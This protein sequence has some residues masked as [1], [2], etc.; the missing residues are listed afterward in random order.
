MVA[1]KKRRGPSLED[2][3]LGP[4]P[5]YHGAVIADKKLTTEYSQGSHWYNYFHTTKT[6]LPFILEYCTKQLNYSEDDIRALKKLPDWKVAAGVGINIR[7][8]NAGFPLERMHVDD[9]KGN[10]LAR[11]KTSLDAVLV[12][13]YKIKEDLKH[14]P[15]PVVIPIQERMRAKVMQTMYAE[16]DEMVVDKWIDG[17]FDDIRFPTYSLLQLH[18]IKGAAVNMFAT[19]V[20]FEYDLV[21]DAYN[22]NCEQA[23]EA[24][25]HI[26][27]SNLKKM[28]NTMDKIFADIQRLKDN[29]KATRIPKAKMPKASDAQIKN[30]QYM[31]RDDAAKLVS[32]NPIMIPKRNKLYVYNTKNK[33]LTK[34][35][36]DTSGGFEVRGSTV[37]NWDD[38]ESMCTTLRKPDDVLPQI[39]T[40]TEKQIDKILSALT[41]KV[42]KPSG[43]INKDCILLR[44]L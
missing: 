2:K 37:Y 33:Q 12:E 36:N 3:Y 32:V 18:K 29:N 35:Y 43:R 31:E 16:W 42:K 9:V 1:K 38:K 5:N 41:T 26:K 15:K 14:V 11:I 25:S 39:L 13:G 19:Y 7:M 6:N 22:K 40:K 10:Y 4:E 17:E 8:Y 20:Q 30:L 44:V 34:Y 21:S 23:E 28:M 24:Y 27:K